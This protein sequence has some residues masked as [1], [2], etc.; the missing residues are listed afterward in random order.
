MV[1][2]KSAN[3]LAVEGIK[4]KNGYRQI[5]EREY[6]R[7]MEEQPACTRGQFCVAHEKLHF[8][9]KRSEKTNKVTTSSSMQK[10]IA[11]PSGQLYA[12]PNKLT[13]IFEIMMPL[14]PPTSSGARKSPNVNTNANVAP[15]RT[16]GSESGRITRRNVDRGD[17]PRSCEAST[18]LRGMCS[19]EA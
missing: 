17:A 19:R 3:A 2:R 9:S 12:A 5:Q 6:N 13:T 11:A 14:G 4:D 8:F 7:G 15:A 16:P 18:R 10:E 1:R